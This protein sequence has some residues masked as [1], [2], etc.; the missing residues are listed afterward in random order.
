MA[1]SEHIELLRRGVDVWNAWR[2]KERAS[3]PDLAHAKLS[4]AHLRGVDLNGANLRAANLSYA[5]LGGAILKGA[6][7]FAA[8]LREADHSD[9]AP[10]SS[11]RSSDRPG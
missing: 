9:P 8:I 6:V 3:V 2:K 5:D 7:L 4:G 1:N 10:R 11:R